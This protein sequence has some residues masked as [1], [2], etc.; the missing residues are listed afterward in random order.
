MNTRQFAIALLSVGLALPARAAA[1]ET[2]PDFRWEKALAAGS[3]VRVH[4][5]SGSVVVT[6]ENVN[7]VEVVGIKRG[8]RRYFE[9]ITLEVVETSRGIIVCPL[10]RDRD[11][12]C[13]E[14]GFRV[15]GR[16][17]WGDRDWDDVSID[18]R[19]RVPRSMLVHASSVSGDVS[20]VG[21][22]GEVRASS[23]SGD[24]R[25]EGLRASEVRGSSVSGDVDVG[26]A[27]L[28]GNGPLSFTSV[29]G[30]VTLELPRNVAADVTMRSVSGQ[31]ETDFPLTLNGRMG[32]NRVEARIGAGGR[33]LEVR[34]V[35]GD[36]RLR[37]AR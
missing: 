32:R 19:V 25:M 8:S 17:R 22:E 7:R 5:L 36:V 12:E 3:S 21:A 35:S 2:Q 18:I 34:T 28:T 1:Q 23:V 4:N 11:M 33:D 20:V 16:S 9:E 31:L 13:G 26:I 37:A 27:V 15:R 10:Y 24:V 30:D 6:A 14:D 29:S